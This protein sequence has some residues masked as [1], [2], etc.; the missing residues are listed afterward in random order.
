M[1][2]IKQLLR[3]KKLDKLIQSRKTGTPEELASRLELSRSQLY[4][5]L[6]ELKDLGAPI[7]YCRRL[8][9]F[10]YS[11]SFQITI[12]AHLEFI[13]PQGAERIYGGKI[14]NSSFRPMQLDGADRPL[15]YQLN[16]SADS[17]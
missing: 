15:L 3:V 9:S 11:E 17:W 4:N 14:E 2:A 7:A 13:T 8:R 10:Y 12:V 16:F 1:Q 5:I 6:E